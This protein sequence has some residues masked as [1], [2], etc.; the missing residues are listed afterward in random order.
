MGLDSF[1]NESVSS[2]TSKDAMHRWHDAVGTYGSG[3][4]QE[5][6]ISEALAEQYKSDFYGLLLQQ[7]VRSDLWYPHLIINKFKSSTDYA[8][9]TTILLINDSK[10]IEQK[11]KING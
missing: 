7:G 9:E 5:V 3:S 11:N 6:R 10:L 1:V 8:G 4:Y 2:V